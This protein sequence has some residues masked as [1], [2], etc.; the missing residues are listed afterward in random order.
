MQSIYSFLSPIDFRYLQSSKNKDKIEELLS[1]KARIN[2]IIFI[3]KIFLECL[4]EQK[5]INK[6]ILAKDLKKLEKITPEM[7]YLEEKRIKHDIRAIVNLI[8]KMVSSKTSRFVHLGLT[9]NDVIDSS[10]NYRLK[11]AVNELVLV[12]AKKLLKQLVLLSE[13]HCSTIQVGRTHGQH[14]VPTTFGYYLSF[15]VE[16][17]GFCV[18]EIISSSNKLPAMLSGATG[19]SAGLKLYLENPEKIE[20]RFAK[21]LGLNYFPVSSQIA[22]YEARLLLL[23]NFTMLFGVLAN[24]ADDFRHLQ[25]TE[26][27]EISELFEKNQVGSSTMPHKMNPIT[28]ENIKSLWKAFFPKMNT[29]YLD[30]IS[31]HQRDLTNSASQRFVFETVFALVYCL[32]KMNSCMKKLF[33]DKKR[34]RKNFDSSKK[35]MIAEPFYIL[36]SLQG[37][38][39]AYEI[40]RQIALKA[41]KQG[42]S[43]LEII[44][45]N[46]KI[47]KKIQDKYFL[48][49][50]NPEKYTG[51]A[52]KRCLQVCRKWKK[53]LGDENA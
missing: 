28:F 5:I 41:K 51:N 43:I 30:Q 7:V 35:T 3:E 50:E 4:A 53:F 36:L 17:I 20:K 38:K 23:H 21:K 9:S 26:I 10:V 11:R 18:K 32:E 12:E 46:K 34:M 39:N 45:E 1:E 25:R 14:A 19:T 24:M 29:F 49:L 31:E 16:R 44:K 8:K 13:S 15:F 37:E 52:K 27:A 33:A 6:K 48:L 42:T 22:L 47:F 40:T 2:S